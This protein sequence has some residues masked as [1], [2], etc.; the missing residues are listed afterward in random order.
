MGNYGLIIII[1]FNSK[2]YSF[3][4]ISNYPLM[5]RIPTFSQSFLCPGLVLGPSWDGPNKTYVLGDPI[6]TYALLGMW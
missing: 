6:H 1:G 5:G 2:E 4:G 3:N